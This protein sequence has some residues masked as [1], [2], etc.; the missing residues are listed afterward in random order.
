MWSFLAPML[1]A[2]KLESSLAEKDLGILGGTELNMSKGGLWYLAAAW[3]GLGE[4]IH[5]SNYPHR[6]MERTEP[7]PEAGLSP[8]PLRQHLG[9]WHRLPTEA[10]GLLPEGLPELP[11]RGAGNQLGG[12][13]GAGLGP[14]EPGALSA[15]A[16]LG[17]CYCL[18]CSIGSSA[19]VW[20]I[21]SNTLR[22]WQSA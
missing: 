22:Y 7:G 13:A 15:S 14:V 10:G 8:Q 11:G 6:G 19:T 12:P 4:L 1:G 18:H 20:K 21:S 17:F 3:G 2:N 5:V 16:G 9:A